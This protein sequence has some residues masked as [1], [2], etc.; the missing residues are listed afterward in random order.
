MLLIDSIIGYYPFNSNAND[1]SGNNN[2]GTVNGATLTMMFGN[3]NS[4]YLFDGID[5]FI[6]LTRFKCNNR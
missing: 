2:N 6:E 5:D 1:E 3:P 4:A